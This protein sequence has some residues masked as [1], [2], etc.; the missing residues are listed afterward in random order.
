MNDS[1]NHYVTLLCVTVFVALLY[2]IVKGWDTLDFVLRALFSSALM[3]LARRNGL[4][5]SKNFS[6]PGAGHRL[7]LHAVCWAVA[8]A[9]LVVG[10]SKVH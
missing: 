4:V 8:A 2:Q 3:V 9:V 7:A 6:G 5:V 10:Y 1:R